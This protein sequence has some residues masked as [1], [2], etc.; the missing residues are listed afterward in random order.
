M[1]QLYHIS[2]MGCVKQYAKAVELPFENENDMIV[3]KM[4]YLEYAMRYN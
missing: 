1:I 4:L 3:A 2:F